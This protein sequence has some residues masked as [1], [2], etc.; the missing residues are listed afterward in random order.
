MYEAMFPHSIITNN[1][2]KPFFQN[3]QIAI[4]H[5]LT[6][7]PLSTVN[8]L[9]RQNVSFQW[10][11]APNSIYIPQSLIVLNAASNC[12]NLSTYQFHTPTNEHNHVGLQRGQG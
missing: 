3:Q 8:N 5:P 2:N 12:L 4:H 6:S 11:L 1:E 9:E 10:D 7:H